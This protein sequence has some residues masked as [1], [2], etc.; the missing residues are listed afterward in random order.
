MDDH[1]YADMIRQTMADL[2]KRLVNETDIDVALKRVT[3]ASVELISG[4][5]YADV[6]VISS[7]QDY[8]SL[9]PTSQLAVDVDRVQQRF[10]EGPCVDAA[11]NSDAVVACDDLHQDARWPRFAA[12]AV[13][14]GVRSILSFPL[15]TYD[16]N[17]AALNLFGSQPD[18]FSEEAR[19]LGAMMATHAALVL[20]FHDKERQFKSALASRD[21]IGQAKGMIMERFDVDAV[22]AFELLVKLS[23]NTNTPVANIAAE[24]IARGSHSRPRA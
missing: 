17:V 7:P 22:H 20:L 16:S 6:L 8:R 19:A 11:A 15:Y 10:Q 14:L 9:A 4:V 23:Q 1:E 24:I 12:A 13:A 21:I 5:H 3:E 18:V 2:T